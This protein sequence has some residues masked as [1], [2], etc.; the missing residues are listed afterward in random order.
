MWKNKNLT[1]AYKNKGGVYVFEWKILFLSRVVN[2]GITVKNA[3]LLSLSFVK[4]RFNK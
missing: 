2:V 3:T 4:H 1:E